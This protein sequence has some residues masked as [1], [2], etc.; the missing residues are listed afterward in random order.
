MKKNYK[1]RGATTLRGIAD[2]RPNF[3]FAEYGLYEYIDEEKRVKKIYRKNGAR[4]FGGI[5]DF[6]PNFNFAAI[7]WT[8]LQNKNR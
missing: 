2:F 8:L 5:A 6:W 7:F 4:T 3:N 1:K